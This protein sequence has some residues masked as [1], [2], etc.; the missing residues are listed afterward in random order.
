M[1]PYGP[2]APPPQG[3]APG[4][5]GGYYPQPAPMPYPPMAANPYAPR[6]SGVNP[7]VW[8]GLIGGLAFAFFVAGAF[9]WGVAKGY[10]AAH[11]T[12]AP[13][14]GGYGYGSGYGYGTGSGSGSG[15][16]YDDPDYGSGSGSGGYGSGSGGFG[17]GSG[18]LGG[19]GT[20]TGSGALGHGSGSGSGRGG[21]GSLAPKT[22]LDLKVLDGCSGTDL[23]QI[24]KK[25]NDALDAAS[26]LYGEGN[27]DAA[28]SLYESSAE[29][30]ERTLSK[31]CTGPVSALKASRAKALTKSD[32][33]DKADELRDTFD[34]LL[35][36]SE[37]KTMGY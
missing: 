3:P 37:R 25:L 11:P 16:A 27:Y 30:V 32:A 5:P 23:S 24:D 19:L 26:P 7:L 33:G 31:S 29:T 20:G 10:K 35:D 28:Y 17:S 6:S 15:S 2:Y 22:V 14:Y 13:T 34:S 36:V 4:G 1:N 9:S 18:G 12:P 21:L 8:L